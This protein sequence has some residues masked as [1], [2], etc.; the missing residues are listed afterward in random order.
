MTT[1][2]FSNEFDVLYN[3]IASNLLP[4]LDEY[5]KSVLLTKAQE[6]VIVSL[7][8]GKNPSGDVFERNEEIRR[9]LEPLLKDVT[10]TNPSMDSD[11]NILPDTKYLHRVYSLPPDCLFIVYE[12]VRVA[13]EHD[14]C[15]DGTILNVVPVPYD[16]YYKTLKNPFKSPNTRKVL[17]IEHG[18]Y[19][20]ELVS[21]Y[22]IDNY[23]IKYISK[24]EPIILEDL[25]NNLSINGKSYKTE[26]QL[27]PALHRYILEL[28]VDLAMASNSVKVGNTN[29]NQ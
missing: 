22:Y 19:K 25:S 13:D 26:C 17:R 29:S 16:D 24:P 18:G 23:T 1:Q 5:E 12:Q 28:A 6:Q 10:L 20:V 27:H 2:E 9:Y 11:A 21:S 14:Q 15:V 3:S 7:Y 4:G 8:N